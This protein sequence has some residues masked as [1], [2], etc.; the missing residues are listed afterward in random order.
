MAKKLKIIL[1]FTLI[2]ILIGLCYSILK[3]PTY[4]AKLVFLLNDS[5]SVG[6]GSLNAL[7]GQLGLGGQSGLNVSEDRVFYLGYSKRIIGG[8][9]LSINDNGETLGDRLIAIRKL[10]EAW[11]KDTILNQFNSFKA[12]SI[13]TLSLPEN[14][15]LDQLVQLVLLSKKYSVDSYKKKVASLVGSQNSGMMFVS[16]EFSDESFA[17]DFVQSVF[18]ELSSFYAISAIKSLQTNY[19]LISYREDSLRLELQLLEGQ[20]ATTID[21]N[22]QVNKFIGKV[23][24]NRLRRKLEILYLFYAEVIKNK[25][26]AKF[27]LEQERPVFQVVDGPMLPLEAKFKSKV[28]Y[29]SLAGF[30]MLLLGIIFFTIIYLWQIWQSNKQFFI[31]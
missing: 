5:K 23:S 29:S 19:D 25:E 4:E 17:K 27:N 20:M 18:N 7:A 30:G 14:K 8:A 12:R 2:G 15:A 1:T 31:S 6:V 24:E 21:D 26:V 22:F 9:L 16:F 10:K 28:V 11:T 13:S 3:K